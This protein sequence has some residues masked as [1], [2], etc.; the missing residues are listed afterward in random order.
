M[1]E[2]MKLAKDK[3]QLGRGHIQVPLPVG[4]KGSQGVFALKK[5]SELR[6]STARNIQRLQV[7]EIADILKGSII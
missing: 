5:C 7:R 3:E 4:N 2:S 1:L 6:D